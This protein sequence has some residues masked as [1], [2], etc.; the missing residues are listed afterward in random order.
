MPWPC[1]A[2]TTGSGFF[3][4]AGP[5]GASHWAPT[6]SRPHIGGVSEIIRE[7]TSMPLGIRQDLQQEPPGRGIA[8]AGSRTKV[9]YATCCRS[10]MRFSIIISRSVGPCSGAPPPSRPAPRCPPGYRWGHPPIVEC[11]GPA[12]PRAVP[13]SRASKSALRPGANRDT[14]IG[15]L[16]VLEITGHFGR[17]QPV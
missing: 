4:A 12:H 5:H 15:M 9:V 6:L 14:A 10:S 7:L 2:R 8:L 16:L 3:C 1:T 17:P 13:A 11:A